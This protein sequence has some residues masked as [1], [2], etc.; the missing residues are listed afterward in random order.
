M[1]IY[2]RGANTGKKVFLM[3]IKVK[4]TLQLK[5]SE[6]QCRLGCVFKGQ[7]NQGGRNEKL[8]IKA[9]KGKEN[10]LEKQERKESAQF[11]RMGG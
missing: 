1:G 5:K 3:Q 2:F 11:K 9:S 10:Q 7:R 8:I 6:Q 4:T